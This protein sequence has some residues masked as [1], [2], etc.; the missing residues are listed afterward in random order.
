MRAYAD[1]VSGE[2]L[3]I[4]HDTYDSTTG[5]PSVTRLLE[6]DY[7]YDKKDRSDFMERIESRRDKGNSHP[8]HVFGDGTA[9]TGPRYR[10]LSVLL[11]RV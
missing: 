6:P 1:I 5:W 7:V 4:S 9:Q 2:P 8:G 11:M 3:L 10:S